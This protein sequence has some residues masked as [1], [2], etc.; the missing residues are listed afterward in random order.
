MSLIAAVTGV[1]AGKTLDRAYILVGGVTFGV[2]APLPALSQMVQG[3]SVTL[4][5][6]LQVREDDLSLFG[7]LT[8]DER[9]LFVTLLGVS[10]IG[11]RLGMAMLAAQHPDALRTAVVQEDLDRLA[12]IPGIG[13]KTAQRLVLEMKPKLEKQLAG[14][15]LAPG[16]SA[17]QR[18][19]RD[20]DVID[21]LTG[22][23]YT[24]AEAQ[25][26]L[27]AIPDAE[28]LALDELIVKALRV[29]AR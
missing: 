6:H 2:F 24:A 12:R 13:K 25:A 27:R 26:A 4:F 22:L 8:E 28:H 21:A 29:L 5:T 3:E 11:A 7:F 9:D 20:T 17:T 19:G 15:P 1:V 16:A 14:R 23:G 18:A 10:G